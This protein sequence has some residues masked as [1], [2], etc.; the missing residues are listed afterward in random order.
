VINTAAYHNVERCET[1]A[2]RAFAVNAVAVDSLAALCAAADVALAHISTDY[3]FDGARRTPYDEA[4]VPAPLNVYGISKY[5]GELAIAARTAR[6]FI[7]RTSGLYGLRG[8][9]TKGYTFVERIREQALAGKPL[10]IVD[11]VTTTPSYTHDVAQTMRAIVESGRFGTYHV[12]NAGSCTWYGFATEILASLNI[13]AEIE[14]TTSDAFPSY[15]RRPPYSV[16]ANAALE[17][18]GV[19]PARSWQDGLHAYL[20]ART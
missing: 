17:R 16:L 7:F 6:A 20:E 19:A 12:T 4:A 18:I 3:V 11:D 9:S 2:A 1:H 15:A 14:A 10:R 13:T 5:A 8:S